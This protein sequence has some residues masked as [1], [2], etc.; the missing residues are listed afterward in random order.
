MTARDWL[1]HVRECASVIE[2]LHR[3]LS[4]LEDARRDCL[5]WQTKGSTLYASMGGTHSD[6]TASE[7]QAR[8]DGLDEQIGRVRVRYDEC[9][10]VVGE[11]GEVLDAMRRELGE[12]YADVLELYYVDCADTWSE[13]SWEMGRHRDTVRAWRDDAVAWIDANSARYGMIW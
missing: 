13:V 2:S 8:M 12:R 1:E 9:V 3:E 11:C 10:R 5:P 6:P 4:A 7:A